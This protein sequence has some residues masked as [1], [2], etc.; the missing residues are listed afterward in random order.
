MR[1]NITNGLKHGEEDY[2]PYEIEL[3]E[4]FKVA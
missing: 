1:I 3:L 2:T 4:L